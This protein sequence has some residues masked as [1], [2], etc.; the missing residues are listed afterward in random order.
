VALGKTNQ[1]QK[2][3]PANQPTNQAP[4]L[5]KPLDLK[6]YRGEGTHQR[7]SVSNI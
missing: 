3:Q 6:K 1:Q 7:D 4:N 5:I 2:N